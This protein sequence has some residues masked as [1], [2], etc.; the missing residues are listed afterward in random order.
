MD[1][2]GHSCIQYKKNSLDDHIQNVHENKKECDLC[3]KTFS[4]ASNLK[5]H[6][7]EVHKR[8]NENSN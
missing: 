3:P 4:S 7:E 5:R 2:C 6:K 8:R 1:M